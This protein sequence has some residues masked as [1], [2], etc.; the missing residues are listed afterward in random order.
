MLLPQM[1]GEGVQMTRVA[2]SAARG[3]DT[4]PSFATRPHSPAARVIHRFDWASPCAPTTTTRPSWQATLFCGGL[5]WAVGIAKLAPGNT[6]RSNSRSA[7]SQRDSLFLAQKSQH[8]QY[9]VTGA[10]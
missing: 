5:F 4:L 1:V 8:F 10:Y 2:A 9:R 7:G 6:T 3:A